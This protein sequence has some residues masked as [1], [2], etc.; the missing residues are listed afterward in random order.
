MEPT[1]S[2]PIVETRMFTS[3]LAESADSGLII[4]PLMDVF[5]VI[6]I[7]MAMASNLISETGENIA[8]PTMANVNI[9][10]V[11]KEVITLTKNS[12]IFFDNRALEND[13]HKLKAALTEK[14]SRAHGTDTVLILRADKDTSYADVVKIL[15]IARELRLK[16]YL[17]TEEEK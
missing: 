5:F 10:N 1:I 6:L 15:A 8:P 13:M 2:K 16:L 7:F 3:R 17:V 14:F 4:I 9:Q 11:N 12:Q